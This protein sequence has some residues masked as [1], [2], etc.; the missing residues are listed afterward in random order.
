MTASSGPSHMPGPVALVGSGEFLP[1][2]VEVDRLLLE[3]RPRRVAVI[4]TAAGTEGDRSVRRWLDLAR[5]H[6][7]GLGASVLEVDVR[8]HATAS[9]W[10]DDFADVG[11]IYLSGGKPA[12]LV[13]SLAGTPLLHGIL[14]AWHGGAALAGCSAG[15]MA[16]AEVLVAS[17]W[18]AA[19]D[20]T[21]GFG[22]VRGIGVLPHFDRYVRGPGKTAARFV[23]RPPEGI[24]VIGIDENTALV[25]HGDTWQV[26]GVGVAWKVTRGGITELDSTTVATP[27]T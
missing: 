6:Y 10:A 14:A 16:L 17:P 11:L 7:G 5:R 21:P 27:T 3:G 19:E 1:G 25:Q 26:H 20:W 22:V 13:G 9:A 12:H 4:P 23:I 8:D 18:R 24:Q 2:M 15:A